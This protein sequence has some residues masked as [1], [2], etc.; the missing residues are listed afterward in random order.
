MRTNPRANVYFGHSKFSSTHYARNRGPSRAAPNFD[1]AAE[2]T[3]AR[4]TLALPSKHAANIRPPYNP[5]IHA[6]LS[7]HEAW[8]RNLDGFNQYCANALSLARPFYVF[9][10]GAMQQYFSFIFGL[11]QWVSEPLG[12]KQIARREGRTLEG[13]VGRRDGDGQCEEAQRAMDI[14]IGATTEMWFEMIHE[15]STPQQDKANAKVVRFATA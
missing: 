11:P 8:A 15:G 9:P 3:A 2:P 1:G 5:G 6:S 12:Q 13:P 7:V 4:P 14:A 10:L